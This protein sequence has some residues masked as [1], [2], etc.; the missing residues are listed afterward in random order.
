[1]LDPLGDTLAVV[2]VVGLVGG[3]YYLASGNRDMS[4]AAQQPTYQQYDLAV[5]DAATKQK[6]GAYAMIGGAVFAGLAT[7]RLLSA[8]SHVAR[9]QAASV[10]P[11]PVPGGAVLTYDGRF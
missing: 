1:M 8:H 3:G 6:I 2:G 7:W 9:E 10:V 5:D 11:V 4:A